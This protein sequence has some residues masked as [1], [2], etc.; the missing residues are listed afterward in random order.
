MDGNVLTYVSLRIYETS[1]I[2]QERK[3]LKKFKFWISVTKDLT[4]LKFT[5]QGSP[6]L[7]FVFT[8]FRD[9]QI[10]E[11]NFQ[12]EVRTSVSETTKPLY[13]ETPNRKSRS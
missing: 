5:V 3:C 9:I 7:F 2:S 11:I 6:M 8:Y 13:S 10:F 4:F 1:F 12:M